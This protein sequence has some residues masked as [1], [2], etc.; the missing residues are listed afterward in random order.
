[1][2]RAPTSQRQRSRVRGAQHL[3]GAY[4]E[5]EAERILAK[6]DRL[7]KRILIEIYREPIDERL[8]AERV[9]SPLKEVKTRLHS[10]TRILSKLIKEMDGNWFLTRLGR[11]ICEILKQNPVFKGYFY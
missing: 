9:S 8:I 7:D 3:R 11:E 2:R 1:M 10:R 5:T 4:Y 6:L